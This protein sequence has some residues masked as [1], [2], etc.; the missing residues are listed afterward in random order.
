MALIF[1]LGVS[2]VSGYQFRLYLRF[3]D[4]LFELCRQCVIL[5]FSCYSMTVNRL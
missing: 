5:C 3:F 2:V 4:W 1:L